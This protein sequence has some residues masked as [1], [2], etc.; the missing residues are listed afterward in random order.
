VPTVLHYELT[1]LQK[2]IVY[3]VLALIPSTTARYRGPATVDLRYLDYSTLYE[4]KL[5]SLKH[6]QYQLW[7]KDRK[8]RGISRQTIANALSVCGMRRPRSGRLAA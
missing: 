3:R 2:R 7:K 4:L 5:P 6:I 1:P 8:L